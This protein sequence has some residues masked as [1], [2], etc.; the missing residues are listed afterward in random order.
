MTLLG[1][2]TAKIYTYVGHIILPLHKTSQMKVSSCSA[3][4]APNIVLLIN[5]VIHEKFETNHFIINVWRNVWPHLQV[6]GWWIHNPEDHRPHFHNREN[7]KI[8][9]TSHVAHRA[10]PL[11]LIILDHFVYS[12]YHGYS[13]VSKL[14]SGIIIP[15]TYSVIQNLSVPPPPSFFLH[16]FYVIWSL[17]NHERYK[18]RPSLFCR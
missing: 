7:L 6:S 10:N 9:Y 15:L 14:T 5:C 13:T 17:E 2:N 12:E 16:S 18:V 11:Q 1:N 4:Y 3:G 8:S